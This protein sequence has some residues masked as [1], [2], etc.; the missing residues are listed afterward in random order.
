MHAL[1]PAAVLPCHRRNWHIRPLSTRWST[2]GPVGRSSS[3]T[4]F[5]IQHPRRPAVQAGAGPARGTGNGLGAHG[6]CYFRP[7]QMQCGS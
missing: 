5:G 7:G 6:G 3:P 2:G 1:L 4:S